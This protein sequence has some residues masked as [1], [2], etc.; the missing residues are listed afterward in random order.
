MNILSSSHTRDIA[1]WLIWLIVFLTLA[2][3]PGQS[4]QI[5]PAVEIW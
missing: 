4:S 1:V 2:W 5:G 3:M